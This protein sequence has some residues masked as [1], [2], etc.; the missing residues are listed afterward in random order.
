MSK[1]YK[2]PYCGKTNS[3][4]EP[5]VFLVICNWCNKQY[6]TEEIK[7]AEKIKA[8]PPKSLPPWTPGPWWAVIKGEDEHKPYTWVNSE[9]HSICRDMSVA[10]AR[11]IACAPEMAEYIEKLLDDLDGDCDLYFKGADLIQKAEGE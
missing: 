6:L 4:K 7:D 2:C 9:P 11:L 8:E 5:T 10:D 1:A 3:Y